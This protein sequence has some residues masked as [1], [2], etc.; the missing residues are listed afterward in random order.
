MNASLITRLPGDSAGGIETMER[1]RSVLGGLLTVTA[2]TLSVSTELSARNHVAAYRR[3][4]SDGAPVYN[5]RIGY[6]QETLASRWSIPD[7]HGTWGA[8]V[9][10]FGI[11]L[12][13]G[14]MA[15]RT[16]AS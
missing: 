15:S 4:L 5:M 11:I 9:A 3:Q 6:E 1:I 10:L 12:I 16:R 14:P 2:L 7:G 8:G 13:V